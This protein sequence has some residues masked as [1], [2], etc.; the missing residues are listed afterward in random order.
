VRTRATITL[1]LAAFFSLS[2]F[3]Q[4]NMQ[5]DYIMLVDPLDEPEF[6]CFDLAGWGDHLQL[7]DPLQ[8]HTC[9]VNNGADQMFALVDNKVQVT[10]TDRCVQVAGS[11]GVTLPGSAVLARTCADNALQDLSLNSSGKIEIGESGYCIGSG[12]ESRD[13]SGPSHVWRTMIVVECDAVDS[14]LATWQVG[15]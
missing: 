4:D 13:A 7:D 15:L 1:F 6:Y 11:S 10:G 12:A 3:A 5:G 9:K 8:T 2:V 14:S